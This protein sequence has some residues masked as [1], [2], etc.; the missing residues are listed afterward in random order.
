MGYTKVTRMRNSLA[1][2]SS[3][4]EETTNKGP[5]NDDDVY[6]EIGELLSTSSRLKHANTLNLEAKISTFLADR[7]HQTRMNEMMLYCL[8]DIQIGKYKSIAEAM[9]AHG[10]FL[11]KDPN[12]VVTT[13]DM[14]LEQSCLLR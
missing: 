3:E 7:Q 12:S 2:Q 5:D 6:K 1:T 14:I 10:L 4:A 8:E 9:R 11:K 13:L